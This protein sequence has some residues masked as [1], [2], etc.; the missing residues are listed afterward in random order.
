[1]LAG[2]GSWYSQNQ[3]IPP[4]IAAWFLAALFVEAA[5]YLGAG[6][7]WARRLVE[8]IEPPPIR[9]FMLTLAALVPYLVYA[10]GTGTLNWRSFLLLA[11]IA[12][13]VSA[14]FVVAR[15]QRPLWDI[16]FV[17]LLA[18]LILSKVFGT[19]YIT[20]AHKADATILGFLMLVHTGAFYV[21]T[22]RKKG[23]VGFSFAPTRQDWAV[24]LLSFVAIF[25]CILAANL[26][27]QTLRPQL[28][29]G[30]WWR[31]A[32]IALGTFLAFL[33]VTALAEEFVFR[34]ILQH[35]LAK[36]TGP[37]LALL[38]TSLLFGLAHLPFRQFPNWPW[39]V[40]ASIIGL[41]CGLATMRTGSI[42]AATV[43]HAL[44]VA[45]WRTFFA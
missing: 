15:D 5:L 17:G 28:A 38:I 14:W 39:V 30:P 21:M 3:N 32:A 19:I 42:R 12:T 35:A 24:G 9:A 8:G 27:L 10:S 45:T 37:L 4:R 20:L 26:Y 2:I 34:G 25:G 23:G 33:W 7:V 1:V 36:W 11:G 16:L 22:I 41:F 29:A 18:G 13:V 44:V 6:F 40:F 43:A 31:I